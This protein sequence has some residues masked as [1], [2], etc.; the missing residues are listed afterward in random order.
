MVNAAERMSE[1]LSDW[2]NFDSGASFR[3]AAPSWTFN[4]T[5]SG[6]AKFVI[7]GKDVVLKRGHCLIRRPET[8]E[9]WSVPRACPAG[10]PHHWHCIYVQF[11]PRPHWLPWLQFPEEGS[12]HAVLRLSNART[13]RRVIRAMKRV[14][15]CAAGK[16]VYDADLAMNALERVILMCWIDRNAKLAHIDPRVRMAMCYLTESAVA[17]S[18]ETLARRCHMSR[19][20]FAHLFWEASRHAAH[21]FSRV[22]ATGARVAPAAHDQRAGSNDCLRS[23]FR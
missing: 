11:T 5:L 22:A 17:V 19:A 20:Q 16:S 21:A 2:R 1:V 8:L 4:I 15:R 13:A 3:G 10:R 14:F 6:R 9:C 23:W 12:D 18:L 7:G